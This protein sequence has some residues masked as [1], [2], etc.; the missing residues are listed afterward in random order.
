MSAKEEGIWYAAYG[1][2]L[3]RRRFDIYLRG[4]RPDGATHT[5]PGCRDISD[6]ADEDVG[7]IPSEL[8]FGGW[9]QTWGGGVAF[10]RPSETARSKVRLYLITLE[11]FADVVAQENWLK[12]GS[13][14]IDPAKDT[15]LDGRMYGVVPRLGDRE[16][17]P[18][19]TI[20]QAAQTEI[21]V[22]APAYLRPIA[23]GLAEAH[24]LGADEIVAYLASAPGAPPPAEVARAVS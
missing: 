10:V 1:S 13:I 5:Y 15:V 11:Q 18:V 8:C 14:E 3:S 2:N 22:P 21:A 7:D 6:P 24:G 12:P 9:S 20:T 17:L 16:G 4:G 23:E 19:L